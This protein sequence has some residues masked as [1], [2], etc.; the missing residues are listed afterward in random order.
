MNS[1]GERVLFNEGGGCTPDGFGKGQDSELELA[2]RLLDLARLQPR[3][4]AL[5]K[6]HER[7]DGQGAIR[8]GVDGPGCLFAPARRPDQNIGIKDHFDF[9][10]RSCFSVLV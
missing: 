8:C 5:K 6:L 7:D 10:E 1:V 4:R 3:S 9:R 2:K